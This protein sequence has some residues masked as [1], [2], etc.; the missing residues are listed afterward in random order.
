VST[1]FLAPTPALPSDDALFV[2]PS[3]FYNFGL[4]PLREVLRKQDGYDDRSNEAPGWGTGMHAIIAHFMETGEVPGTVQDVLDR[5]VDELL[6]REPSEDIGTYASLEALSVW[7]GEMKTGFDLWLEQFWL[8][9]GQH[10]ETIAAEETVMRPLG[11]LPNGRDV[12]IRGT[13]DRVLM[14]NDQVQIQDWK[15]AGRGWKKG[16]ADSN[17]V[18][19]LSYAW[20]SEHHGPVTRG[21]FVVYDRAKQEWTWSDKS[22][23]IDADRIELGLRAMW[24]MAEQLD[25]GTAV[26]NPFAM[27]GFGDGRGWHCKPKFCS[28][29]NICDFKALPADGVH[30]EIRPR[31]M[32]WE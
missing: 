10:E 2:R 26:A 15:T 11:V 6:M 5:W 17:A 18:Q 25:S 30:V 7:A 21:T 24:S 31:E 29:W 3:S 4:C 28:A 32:S 9:Q 13:P 1:G 20:L 16:K 14:V 27:G 22:F 23:A 19:L 8:P 12:W